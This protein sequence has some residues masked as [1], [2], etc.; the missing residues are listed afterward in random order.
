MLRG[1][2]IATWSAAMT[3]KTL[4]RPVTVLGLAGI[5]PQIACLGVVIASPEWRW[6]AMAAGCFY[7]ALIFSFLG[8]LWWMQALL[9]DERRWEPYLI[10]IVASLGGWAALLPW[11]L[12]WTWPGPSLVVLGVAV[13]LSP[14]ADRRLATYLPVPPAWLQLRAMMAAG[15]GVLTMTMGLLAP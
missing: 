3:I 7:A 14:L 2:G 11:C 9:R 13:L 1:T 12:G 5:L 6:V 8:G 15:L 4:P 10:S